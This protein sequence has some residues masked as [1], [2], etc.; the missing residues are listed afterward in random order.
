M[1]LGSGT[2]TEANNI[3]LHIDGTN[4]EQLKSIKLFGVLLDSELNFSEHISFF[5]KKTSQQIGV[6]RRL[7]K[8]IP[9]HA[10]LQLYKAAILPHLTYCSTIWHFCR[11]SDK[12]KVER[13]Q[14]RALR[15]VF[16]NESVSYD[17]MPRLA[18]LPSRVNRR[19]Q[20]IAI[21]MFR[22]KKRLLP[23]QMQERFTLKA[24]CDRRYSLRNF[25][26]KIPRFNTI[27]YGK[28]SIRYFGPFLWSK[29][30]KELRIEDSLHRFKTK[31]RRTDLT[32][33]IVDGCSNC[34]LCNN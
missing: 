25:D 30:T 21:L 28:H 10:K 6:L 12:L 1:L 11:A 19:L 22:A 18:E 14:E 29:L 23:S 34:M 9:T 32:V 7:R 16:N 15:V 24:N 20:E 4:I 2:G 31:I 26:F 33:I 27:K 8:L 17:E 3:N 13:L 5:C